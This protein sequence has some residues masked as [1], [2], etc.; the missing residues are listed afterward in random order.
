MGA[1]GLQWRWGVMTINSIESNPPATYE[2]S[3]PNVC[4][5]DVEELKQALFNA[6]TI[7]GCPLKKDTIDIAW[8]P[9]PHKRPGTLSIGKQAAYCFLLGSTWLKV[10]K[11]GPNSGPRFVSHHYYCNAPSTLAKSILAAK[12][13]VLELLKKELQGEFGAVNETTIGK[14]LEINTSRLNVLIPAQAGPHVLSLV[15]AFLHCRLQPIFE[16]HG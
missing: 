1:E 11:A 14:W 16:G 15:E 9:A 2:V 13:R 7:A 4:P 3:G 12:D 10:G 8:S 6:T 5:I